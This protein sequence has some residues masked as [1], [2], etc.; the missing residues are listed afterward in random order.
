M[1][2]LLALLG[3]LPLLPHPGSSVYAQQMPGNDCL[4]H[5]WTL[6]WDLHALATQPARLWDANIFFPYAD[7]LLYS[8]HLLG[9]AVLLAPLRAITENPV[10]IHNVAT[11]AAPA[12]DAM[13]LY[14]L[15]LELTGS[16]GAALVG[17]LLYGF[18]PVRMETDRCQVQMLVAWWLPLALL[19]TRRALARNSVLAGALAGVCLA[20]QGLTGIY[21]FAFFLPI[22]GLAQLAWMRRFP[23]RTHARGWRALLASEAVAALVLV[24]SALAYRGVQSALDVSRPAVLNAL[25]SLSNIDVGPQLPVL[26]L[27]ALGLLA[28]VGRRAPEPFRTERWLFLGLTLV[29]I[30]LAFGPSMPLPG[31]LGRIRGPYALLGALPGFTALRAPGR[32]IHIVLLTAAVLAAG[33]LAT[34]RALLPRAAAILLLLA[35][36]GASLWEEYVPPGAVLRAPPPASLNPT[37]SWLAQQPHTMRLMEYPLDEFTWAATHYQF[38]STV[39]WQRTAI[40]NMG[41]LPPLYP[42]LAKSMNRFPA[43]DVRATLQQLGITHVVSH[44]APPAQALLTAPASLDAAGLRVVYTAPQS[45]VLELLPRPP[46]GPTVVPGTPLDRRG[47]VATANLSPSMAP[48]AIEDGGTGWNSWGDLDAIIHVWYDAES[49]ATHWQRYLAAQPT[50]FAI[51]LGAEA[52]VT[53]VTLRLGGS[54]PLVAPN[55]TVETSRDGVAWTPLPGRLTPLPDAM[56]FVHAADAHFGYLAERPTVARHVR[57]STPG[58]EWRLRDVQV[59]AGGTPEEVAFRAGPW[60]AAPPARMKGPRS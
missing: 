37:Y 33:G 57:L 50:R 7:T 45:T 20:M 11:V 14:L 49:L 19:F 5:V 25:L 47:W 3:N 48:R 2:G 52:D 30:V 38:A 42:W 27:T 9:L 22:L 32:F 40:G 23:W 29:A 35:A 36:V 53:A 13:A 17:G 26:T 39:H 18:A 16:P 6:A 21:L 24:P 8:D 54:D 4:L 1:F 10:F 55:L 56:T 46:A 58:F 34:A 41:I 60:D 43:P 59:H 31:D 51:D 12:L 28:F 44:L 15:A